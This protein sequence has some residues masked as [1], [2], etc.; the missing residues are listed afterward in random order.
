MVPSPINVTNNSMTGRSTARSTGRAKSPDG[1]APPPIGLAAVA[2]H[3]VRTFLEPQHYS[4]LREL[5]DVQWS[6]GH[7][8]SAALRLLSSHGIHISEQEEM[9]LCDSRTED[10]MIEM[11][12]EKMP[13]NNP[14]QFEHFFLQLSFVASTTTRLRA[15]V[16]NGD[17][18]ACEE[19]LESAENVGVLPFLLK[20][21]V[22]QA[23][24]E[25]IAHNEDY[26]KWLANMESKM[27]GLLTSELD[28]YDVQ[29]T[30]SKATATIMR[31]EL[32]AKQNS[33]QVLLA[34]VGGNDDAVVAAHF[35]MWQRSVESAKREKEIKKEY[36]DRLAAAEATLH[37]YKTEKLDKV[38]SVM[39]RAHEESTKDL[40]TLCMGAFIQEVADNKRSRQ[41]AEENA[42]LQARMKEFSDASLTNAKKVMSRVGAD[43]DRGLQSMVM[44]LWS[45]AAKANKVER[46]QEQEIKVLSDR[47]SSLT[48]NSKSNAKGVL[49]RFTSATDTGLLTTAFQGWFDSISG[50]KQERAEQE[51]E[52]KAAMQMQ[53]FMDRNKASANS[54]LEKR[55]ILQDNSILITVLG[56]WK[57][58]ARLGRLRRIERER[59]SKRKQ[60]LASV[61]GM[62]QNFAGDLDAT[63]MQGTPR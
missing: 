1:K 60:D 27:E 6:K 32:D 24:Q 16:E 25:V 55:A 59:H 53:N 40:L 45:E 19:A 14:E 17:V 42:G 56:F 38:K 9:A 52:Q 18:A 50:E 28:N 49:S 34:M 54:V 57:R 26:D 43:N 48:N 23:G 11:L 37:K 51:T 22:V 15:A 7:T 13:K 20:S 10:R 31:Y 8:V 21:S 63:L 2:K 30:L 35:A 12:V 5:L 58:E 36:E 47:L 44:Q 61:K 46:K 62:F 33:K 4:K 39:T 29:D 41:I 3:V